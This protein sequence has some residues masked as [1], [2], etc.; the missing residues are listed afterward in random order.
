[1]TA[2]GRRATSNG[3]EPFSGAPALKARS[4]S[5]GPDGV[6]DEALEGEQREEEHETGAEQPPVGARVPQAGAPAGVEVPVLRTTS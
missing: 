6:G 3:R 4:L 1:M 5:T 2:G